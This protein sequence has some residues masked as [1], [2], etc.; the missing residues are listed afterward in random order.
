MTDSIK[1]NGNTYY[2]V[3]DIKMVRTIPGHE[4]EAIAARYGVPAEKF[5][6]KL[7]FADGRSKLVQESIADLEGKGLALVDAGNG[8]MIVAQ[9]IVGAKDFS[10]EERAAMEER[11][12]TL[13]DAFKTS[14]ETRAGLVLA[15]T[16]PGSVM[17]LKA[18]ALE[19][20]GRVN[21]AADAQASDA[22]ATAEAGAP[23]ADGV[24]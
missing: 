17:S 11:G 7:T 23:A 10:P 8:R 6:S 24:A 22:A 13:N 12:Y 21:A 1:V 18:R 4:R 16:D 3:A 9:N 14:V 19:K 2:S 15:T 5:Q 20:I